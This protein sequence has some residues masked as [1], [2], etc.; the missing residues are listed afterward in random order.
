MG[1]ITR[2]HGWAQEGCE[3][4]GG[5]GGIGDAFAGKGRARK[6][7]FSFH[8]LSLYVDGSEDYKIFIQGLAA[9]FPKKRSVVDWEGGVGV[10]SEV[11]NRELEKEDNG[12]T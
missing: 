6:N 12:D 5:R 2:K 1:V 3:S 10:D 9:D 8:R 11:G 4:L 7:V